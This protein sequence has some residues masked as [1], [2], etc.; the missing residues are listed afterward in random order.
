VVSQFP[1]ASNF[2]SGETATALA[3]LRPLVRAAF[4]LPDATS[5]SLTDSLPLDI[6]VFPSGV[7]AM[8]MTESECGSTIRSFGSPPRHA[9][10]DRKTKIEARR[11]A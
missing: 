7:K 6:S 1:D 5:H 4:S 3:L 11:T 9:H 2:P 10:V 8:Q